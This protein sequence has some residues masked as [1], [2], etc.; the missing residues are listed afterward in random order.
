LV[1]PVSRRRT[2]AGLDGDLFAGAD[3]RQD[4]EATNAAER[5]APE[6]MS[7]T[8]LAEDS[9]IRRRYYKA[10]EAAGIKH[11]RFHGLRH[12]FGTLAVQGVEGVHGSCRHCDDD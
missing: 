5:V 1:D 6:M 12:T 9:A 4:Q 8:S 7:R 2:R 11:L 3:I 10:L